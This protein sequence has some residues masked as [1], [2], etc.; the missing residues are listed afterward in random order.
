MIVLASSTGKVQGTGPGETTT[1]KMS[2][3]E[4]VSPE[5]LPAHVSLQETLYPV[6]VGWWINSAP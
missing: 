3:H 5:Q 1:P 6:T 2:W 4:H